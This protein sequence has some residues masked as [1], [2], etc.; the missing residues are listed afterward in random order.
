M[1]GTPTSRR[2]GNPGTPSQNLRP[3]PNAPPARGS[4]QRCPCGYDPARQVDDGHFVKEVAERIAASC[5]EEQL[6]TLA[7]CGATQDA[8]LDEV[9][10]LLTGG[11]DLVFHDEV[12]PKAEGA[13]GEPRTELRLQAGA[14]FHYRTGAGGL[15]LL[16]AKRLRMG[17]IKG[18][19]HSYPTNPPVQMRDA[20][21]RRNAAVVVSCHH[22]Y[23]AH[24]AMGC[25]LMLLR[26][27]ER[28]TGLE[29]V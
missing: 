25:N 12:H 23:F 11:L 27:L 20:E 22:G 24:Q 3:A 16:R 4:Q 28:E 8:V 26:I 10:E 6:G 5:T 18:R 7:A 14:T 2:A 21:A 9:R 1:T 19:S 15:L 29:S 13:F 17:Q